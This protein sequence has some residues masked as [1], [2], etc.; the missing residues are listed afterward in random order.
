MALAPKPVSK[1]DTG[2][3][4]TATSSTAKKQKPD[5][6]NYL[7]PRGIEDH[8]LDKHK[9]RANLS[10]YIDLIKELD[11]ILTQLEDKTSKLWNSSAIPKDKRYRWKKDVFP[12]LERCKEE[13]EAGDAEASFN[14]TTKEQVIERYG[15]LLARRGKQKSPEDMVAQLDKLYKSIETREGTLRTD[16]KNRFKKMF[17]NYEK[18]LEKVL[19]D[20]KTDKGLKEQIQEAITRYRETGGGGKDGH[21]SRPGGSIEKEPA[22][23]S[24]ASSAA[25]QESES[26]S[27]SYTEEE[28]YFKDAWDVT[29]LQ[30]RQLEKDH[31]S[32]WE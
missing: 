22:D 7:L 17:R 15:K 9:G 16:A 11:N 25:N 8:V 6:I 1:R 18:Q 26:I 24:H 2:D 31:D 4:P 20:E 21:K 5:A 29:E 19:N 28:T 30:G 3:S 23:A 13:L 27:E 12:L 10:F 14:G 32:Y